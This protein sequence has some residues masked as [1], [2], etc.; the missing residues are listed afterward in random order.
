MH[1]QYVCVCVCVRLC[2]CVCARACV[3]VCATPTEYQ[4]RLKRLQWFG[5]LQRMPD[6]HIQKQILR[7]TP[8]GCQV[9]GTPLQ[10]VDRLNRDL[11]ASYTKLARSGTKQRCMEITN[12]PDPDCHSEDE[13]LIARLKGQMLC[14]SATCCQPRLIVLSWTL[15]GYNWS[16]CGP[17]TVSS[18][19]SIRTRPSGLI[20]VG[21]WRAQRTSM[22]VLWKPC[23]RRR[24]M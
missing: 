15:R 7:S 5:H 19:I 23:T 4:L 2:M 18:R 6:H 9:V 1:I 21:T 16:S 20:Y 14:Q 22:K 13:R 8:K 10:W 17:K 24:T 11:A 12:L 3:C